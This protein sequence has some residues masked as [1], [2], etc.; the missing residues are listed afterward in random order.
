M[1]A[2]ESPKKSAN[3]TN[4]GCRTL[5]PDLTHFVL[6][7]TAPGC[8]PN[9]CL[10]AARRFNPRRITRPTNNNRSPTI[11]KILIQT[12]TT[13]KIWDARHCTAPKLTFL[14]PQPIIVCTHRERQRTGGVPT[15]ANDRETP[16]RLKRAFVI[17]AH[18]TTKA[19]QNGCHGRTGECRREGWESQQAC[20]TALPGSARYRGRESRQ[21]PRL[22]TKV[23]PRSHFVLWMLWLIFLARFQLKLAYTMTEYSNRLSIRPAPANYRWEHS[24]Q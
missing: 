2:L 1:P 10:P 11:L 9:C 19:S 24:V 14:P 23:V 15:R 13:Q 20:C 17:A 12:T 6:H 3:E 4:P 8:I 18:L 5:P 21:E 7:A 22:L 16:S